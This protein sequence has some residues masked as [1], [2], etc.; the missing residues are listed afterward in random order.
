[1]E[2]MKTFYFKHLHKP[3]TV[4]YGILV[5]IAV[6]AGIYQ[7][8]IKEFLTSKTVTTLI[9][10]TNSSQVKKK[11]EIPIHIESTWDDDT[12]LERKAEFYI[13]RSMS[14][15]HQEVVFSGSA[16]V[17]VPENISTTNNT[18]IHVYGNSKLNTKVLLPN[19]KKLWDYLNEGGYEIQL[20]LFDQH[21]Y[22]FIHKEQ[23]LFDKKIIIDG[24]RFWFR[25][26]PEQM[27]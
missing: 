10:E 12:L 27:K 14:P 7:D 24:L 22:R 11:I 6:L 9:P 19:N 15:S 2:K 25:L 3:V 20:L 1:M 13:V 5:V 8:V 18:W 17:I 16:R 23:G 21:G 26:L 4:F